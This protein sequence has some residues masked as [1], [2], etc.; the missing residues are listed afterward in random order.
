MAAP[1]GN[2]GPPP[3]P[4]TIPRLR[5][6]R[7]NGVGLATS[8]RQRPPLPLT[9]EGR[10]ARAPGERGGAAAGTRRLPSPPPAPASRPAPPGQLAG[11][12]RS[13]P[14]DARAPPPSRYLLAAFG[15]GRAELRQR[16]PALLRLAPAPRQAARAGAARRAAPAPQPCCGRLAEAADAED[17]GR[18][19]APAGGARAAGRGARAAD[20]RR[21]EG[22]APAPACRGRRRHV[23]AASGRDRVGVPEEED[24]RSH[25]LAEASSSGG[26][27]NRDSLFFLNQSRALPRSLRR[28]PS[29]ETPFLAHSA[30]PPCTPTPRPSQQQVFLTPFL[31]LPISGPSQSGSSSP[32][33]WFDTSFS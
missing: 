6:R 2:R 30:L 15:P 8:G 32:P 3:N 7:K 9:A 29:A 11:R 16:R 33:S 23:S 17:A 20:A 14:R 18:G 28:R 13:R 10:L 19:G 27:G 12:P 22:A 24:A 1:G 25:L 21:R 26:L 4:H 5:P 31:Q